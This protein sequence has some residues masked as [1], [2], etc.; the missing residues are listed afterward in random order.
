MA[1][2]PSTE[3]TGFMLLCL[4]FHVGTEKLNIGHPACAYTLLTETSPQHP[5]SFLFRIKILQ[6][7][8]VSARFYS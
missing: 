6:K 5:Y 1:L 3:I 2:S 7:T 8:P 4:A